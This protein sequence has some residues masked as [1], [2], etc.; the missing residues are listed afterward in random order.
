MVGAKPSISRTLL[1]LEGVYWMASL[2]DEQHP[3][4]WRMVEQDG[5]IAAHVLYEG[6]EV[7]QFHHQPT[8]AASWLTSSPSRGTDG[9]R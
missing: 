9:L 5:S 4:L 3:W 8:E 1:V 2:Q 6:G 7:L